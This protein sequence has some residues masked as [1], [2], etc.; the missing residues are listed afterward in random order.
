[1]KRSNDVILALTGG[2]ALLFSVGVMAAEDAK[3]KKPNSDPETKPPASAA[4]AAVETRALAGQLVAYGD[5][6]KD[7]LALIVAAKILKS[8]APQPADLKKD[9][10]AVPQD[11]KKEG[12]NKHEAGA[13]LARAKALAAGRQDLLAL[14]A[15]VEAMTAKGA[16]QGAGR[17][18]WDSVAAH[19]TDVY[20][21]TF[22]G[23]EFAA[24]YIEGDGDTDL[25]LYVYDQNGNP[26]C[27]DTDYTDRLYCA[28]NPRWTGPFRI[29][30]QN[31]GDVWNEYGLVTN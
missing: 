9:G 12:G 11:A 1:M 6:A 17:I 24:V 29:K 8:S 20:D 26:I 3:D 4:V 30:V 23:G 2:M 28:W 25:D 7:P 27:S 21:I 18:H 31:R 16:V 13:I 5:R 10:E 15:D 22:R 14:A 19:R